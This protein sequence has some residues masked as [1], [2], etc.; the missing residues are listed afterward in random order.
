MS[1]ELRA[2]TVVKI[3]GAL[4]LAK[5]ECSS[6]DY[7][8]ELADLEEEI[9]KDV[10]LSVWANSPRGRAHRMWIHNRELERAFDRGTEK[11][12]R[13][14]LAKDVMPLVRPR[15]FPVRIIAIK[16][17]VTEEHRERHRKRRVST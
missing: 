16:D 7:F 14:G 1:Y 17:P 2:Q 5:E 3:L 9:R 13:Q 11:T 10:R 4:R 6:M 15:P 8:N 12:I